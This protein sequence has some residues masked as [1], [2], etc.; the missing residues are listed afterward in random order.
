MKDDDNDD[1]SPTIDLLPCPFCGCKSVIAKHPLSRDTYFAAI[2]TNSDND[3]WASS[4]PDTALWSTP[5]GA[6][7]G[8]NKRSKN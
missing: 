4:P 8:W 1:P 6:A 7:T 2:C 5:E 3:C